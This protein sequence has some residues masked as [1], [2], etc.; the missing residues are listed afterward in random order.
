MQNEEVLYW[1]RF[2]NAVSNFCL[3]QLCNSPSADDVICSLVGDELE[4]CGS[5]SFLFVAKRLIEAERATLDFDARCTS[6]E[7]LLKSEKNTTVNLKKIVKQNQ[8]QAEDNEWQLQ[9]QLAH[10]NSILIQE[11]ERTE[12]LSC[13]LADYQS[14]LI[15]VETFLNSDSGKLTLQFE[16]DLALSKLKI[17]ELE[18]DKD[19]LELQMN[20]K[21]RGNSNHRGLGENG[22]NQSK[23]SSHVAL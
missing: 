18:A 8:R 2:N 15:E 12:A 17:A 6:A 3:G 23:V 21:N 9:E 5:H 19:H 4:W 10:S 22:I 20:K 16:E 14:K 13:Q 1:T 7:T 11:K